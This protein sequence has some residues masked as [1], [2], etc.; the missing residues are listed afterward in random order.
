MK[1]YLIT[2]SI[3]VMSVISSSASEPDP[4]QKTL[5]EFRREF[6]SA[7][8]VTWSQELDFSKAV[9]VLAGKRTIAYFNESGELA[10]SVRE[11]FYD[12]LPLTVMTSLEKKFEKADVINIR[13]VNNAEGT[14]YRIRLEAE[15]KKYLVLV[16][17]NG[18]ISD[19]S[20]VK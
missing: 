11:I 17:A 20:K 14:Q 7:Q 1:K 12:Q 10:G 3:L 19:I 15:G 2:T 5:E 4:D 9:F 6:P 8:S 16:Q 18:N 13:E